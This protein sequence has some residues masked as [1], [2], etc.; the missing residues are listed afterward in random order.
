MTR[1]G[2][3]RERRASPRAPGDCF[4]PE[5]REALCGRLLS[6]W[7]SVHARRLPWREDYD[8]YKVL[9]SEFML[10]QTQVETVLPYFERWMAAYPD[11]ASLAGANESE[12][13]KLWEGLGYYSRCRNLLNAAR[14]MVKEGLHLPPSDVGR[15][16]SYPGIGPYTAGAVASVAYN[17]PVP[18]V[19][20]NA[21]RVVARLCDIPLPAGSGALRRRVSEVVA[22]MLPE[23]RARDLNQ[24]LMDLGATVCM[25]H[26]ADCPV[27]PMEAHCLSLRQGIS[28]G[29]PLPRPRAEIRRIDAWGL[30]GFR[31]RACLMRRRPDR[32]LWASMWELPWFERD[33]EDF[34]SDFREWARPWRFSCTSCRDVGQVDFSFTTHRVRAWVVAAEVS[35]SPVL[36]GN[37]D[38]GWRFVPLEEFPKLVLTAP[39]RKFWTEFTK[40]Q[41]TLF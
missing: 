6:D 34:D 25:P 21:E 18:A 41:R 17:L 29:R 22:R 19:D 11:L 8:P 7:F 23:G 36:A 1:R 10:Q 9:V 28:M 40:S 31:E 4:H 32:G 2:S 14:A 27:C 12:V 33:S 26:A 39:A 5:E 38:D 15:L 37:E 24:G 16:R 20:G 30:V 35:A 13:L 3:S